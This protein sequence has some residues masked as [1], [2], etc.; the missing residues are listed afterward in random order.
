MYLWFMILRTCGRN[1]LDRT[2]FFFYFMFFGGGGEREG[3]KRK[4][5]TKTAKIGKE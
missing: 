1:V 2:F 5:K 3:K 4:L